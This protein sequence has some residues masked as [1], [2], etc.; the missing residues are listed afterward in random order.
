MPVTVPSGFYIICACN[1]LEP[2]Q[3]AKVCE[4]MVRF[5]RNVHIAAGQ[6][7]HPRIQGF[8]FRPW[9]WK[10]EVCRYTLRNEAFVSKKLFGQQRSCGLGKIVSMK[11]VELPECRSE[12][13]DLEFQP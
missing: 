3:V 5:R 7:L 4:S 11:R 6:N 9:C 1:C 8:V 13:P 10:K 12:P 2:S